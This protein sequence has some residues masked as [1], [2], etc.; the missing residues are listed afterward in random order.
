MGHKAGDP[1]LPAWADGVDASVASLQSTKLDATT[2]VNTYALRSM[3]PIPMVGPGIDYTGATDSTTGMQSILDANPGATILVGSGVLAFS[4]LTLSKG[5]WLKGS[6]WRDYRDLP[7]VYGSSGWATATSFSGTVLRSSATTGSALT[8]VPSAVMEGSLSDFILIGP[9]TGSSIG[10]Q[11]G[12][13]IVGNS[14]VHPVWSNIK[15][16]NF[17]IGVQTSYVDEGSFRD[18]TINGCG[19]PLNMSTSTN[20]NAFYNLDM[21]RNS[22]PAVIDATCYMNTFYSPIGQSNLGSAFLANGIKTVWVN[23]YFENNVGYGIDIAAGTGGVII[24]P[25]L[26][27][28]NDSIRI[29]SGVTGTSVVGFKTT[30]GTITNAGT[31]TYLQGT[32]TGFLTDTGTG[33]VV[34][35]SAY[36]GSA[37]GPWSGFTPTL[38]GTGW[39][40][41]NGTIVGSY[42]TIGK[43]VHMNVTVTFG[44]TS[45]FGSANPTITLPLTAAAAYGNTRATIVRQTVGYYQLAPRVSSTTQITVWALG[46][47]GAFTTMT[48]TYPAAFAATDVMEIYATYQRA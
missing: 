2:A 19:T 21:Q 26:S 13:T 43:T 44:S 30:G 11:L 39:A 37:F 28:T 18:L 20:Q 29:Q 3:V 5:Q 46:T 34:V 48:G 23:P 12:G 4:T 32:F 40:I 27:G 10:I 8:V 45:T 33:T 14:V 24:A 15:V 25:H 38:G 1:G 47:N 9:G 31:G 36:S 6:G 16:G 22:G 17:S 41:G 42:T 35:D 7:G